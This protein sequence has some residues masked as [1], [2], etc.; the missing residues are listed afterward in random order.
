M[1]S[2]A[3][4]FYSISLTLNKSQEKIPLIQHYLSTGHLIIFYREAAERLQSKKEHEGKTGF[5]FDRVNAV[6]MLQIQWTGLKNMPYLYIVIRTDVGS[7]I[8]AA[9]P[10]RISDSI[11]DFYV[12]PTP[13]LG[14]YQQFN[15]SASVQKTSLWWTELKKQESLHQRLAQ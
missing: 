14:R 4:G 11:Q 5:S 6:E 15:N 12:S 2:F 8:A 13:S 9:S 7:I 1:D 3:K 10:M